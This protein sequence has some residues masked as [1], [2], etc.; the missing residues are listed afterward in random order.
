MQKDDNIHNSKFLKVKT[1][2]NEDKLKYAGL[3]K[4]V[5]IIKRINKF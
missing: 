1:F 2:V 4:E 5:N 3:K